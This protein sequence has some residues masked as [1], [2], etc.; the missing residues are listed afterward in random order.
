M[1]SNFILQRNAYM[2][3]TEQIQGDRAHIFRRVAM[4]PALA[5]RAARSYTSPRL[6]FT[7]L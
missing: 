5:R 4:H 6:R 7:R 2:C 3:D 1:A